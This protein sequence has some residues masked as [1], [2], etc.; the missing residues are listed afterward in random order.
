M[1]TSN[2]KNSTKKW[3]EKLKRQ[4]GNPWFFFFF[5]IFGSKFYFLNLWLFKIGSD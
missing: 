1:Q 2:I 4:G 3:A 5:S